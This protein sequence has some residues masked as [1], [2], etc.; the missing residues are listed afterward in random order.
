MYNFLNK[1]KSFYRKCYSTIFIIGISL[2]YGYLCL[3]Y[4]K[5]CSEISNQEASYRIQEKI[6]EDYQLIKNEIVNLE[7]KNKELEEAINFYK[8]KK[9]D[10]IYITKTETK[11]IGEKVLYE[12][13]PT[14]YVFKFNE[15][16]PVA[17]FSAKEKY[18]FET[19]NLTYK[20]YAVI[21]EKDTLI[22]VTVTSSADNIEYPISSTNSIVYENKNSK[23]KKIFQPN[24]MLGSSVNTDLNIQAT[25]GLSLLKSRNEL[26]RFALIET[27]FNKNNIEL[28]ITPVQ[29]NLGKPIPLISN[30][31]IGAGYQS[32]LIQHYGT[33]NL[34]TEL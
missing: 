8:T 34:T 33:I 9:Q 6:P 27:S 28:G 3:F 11:L 26:W 1:L 20:T 24:I 29:L 4:I 7:K 30:L 21:G 25:I 5:S 22:K 16:I 17:K 23:T 15:K 14:E 12:I 10:I 18:E 13:L 2:L 32:N 19:Y 31:W